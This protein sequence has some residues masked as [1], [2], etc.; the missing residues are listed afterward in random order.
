MRPSS[1]NRGFPAGNP[2]ANA[3]VI[4]VGT[5]A[6][7]ASVVVGFVAFVILGSALIIMAAVIGIRLWWFSRKT[8]GLSPTGTDRPEEP[9]RVGD[10][11]EGEFRVVDGEGDPAD[12][13]GP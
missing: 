10:A 7:A 6:I 5:L 1:A 13:R 4:V 2:L 11:I 8:G 3:L 12:R 9:E